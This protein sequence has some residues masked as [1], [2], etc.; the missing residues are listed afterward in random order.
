VGLDG[1]TVQICSG[2]TL[3]G[4]FSERTTIRGRSKI[5]PPVII[6]RALNMMKKTNRI[7]P[8]RKATSKH[9]T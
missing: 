9:L 6:T 8:T 7:K 5:E 3:K 4:S 2:L 1:F